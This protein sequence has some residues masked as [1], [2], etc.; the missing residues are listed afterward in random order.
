MRGALTDS[1]RFNS[2]QRIDRHPFSHAFRRSNHSQAVFSQEDPETT[3]ATCVAF[4]V[5]RPAAEAAHSPCSAL[6]ELLAT[7]SA[8]QTDL[9]ALDFARITRH[10]AGLAETGLE[11]RIVVD[12]R[13]RHAVAHRAG[14][15]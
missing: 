3:K 4:V 2:F 8:V 6:A 13:T 11:R 7:A 10:E 5:D 1:R 9:L 12:E 14:L 15:T